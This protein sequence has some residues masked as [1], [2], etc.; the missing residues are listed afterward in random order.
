VPLPRGEV[1]EALTRLRELDDSRRALPESDPHRV[2]AR[3]QI[4]RIQDHVEKVAWTDRFDRTDLRMGWERDERPG[5]QVSIHDGVVTLAGV[6]K[7]DG[8]ARLWEVRGAS[9]FV[10]FEARLTIHSGSTARVGIFVSRETARAG[11]TQVEAEVT[12]SRHPEA[13]ANTIQTRVMKRGEEE[14]PYTDVAG[15][16]WKLDTPVLVRIERVGE[17]SDTRVRPPRRRLPR[18]RR[19]GRPEPRADDVRAAPRD[20]RRGQ[21][22]PSGPGRRRRRGDRLPCEVTRAAPASRSSSSWRSS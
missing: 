20:L 11:E 13:G 9:A 18:P 14:L 1:D 10:A 12:L 19:Q 16:E 3:A 8:R 6:F 17:S 7:Q 15:F 21:D 2:W 22:R 5:P 4:A